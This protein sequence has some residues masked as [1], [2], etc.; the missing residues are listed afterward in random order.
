MQVKRET[1]ARKNVRR[2]RMAAREIQGQKGKEF[3]VVDT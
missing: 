3:L 2:L 1:E